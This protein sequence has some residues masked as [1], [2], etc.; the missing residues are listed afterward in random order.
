MGLCV[1]CAAGLAS[2]TDSLRSTARWGGQG[3]GWWT[4]TQW[5]RVGMRHGAALGTCPLS[6]LGLD[7]GLAR[8]T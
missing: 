5:V 2:G 8:R 6:D 4:A 1:W 7:F 3:V